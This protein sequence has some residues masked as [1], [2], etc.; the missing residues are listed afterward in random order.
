MTSN[1]TSTVRS[2]SVPYFSQWES[3]SLVAGIIAGT[4]SPADDPNWAS[5]GAEDIQEYVRWAGHLCGMACLKMIIAA[6]TGRVVPIL[7]LARQS[8]PYGAY[9]VHDEEIR[10]LIYAPFVSY[11][12]E[13]FGIESTV[14]SRVSAAD[15][16]EIMSRSE[17]FLASVHHSIRWANS[18]PANKGGHL[19]LI[20]ASS[21]EHFTF[22]NPSGHDERSQRDVTVSIPTFE[23]YFAG[24]G[25][26]ILPETS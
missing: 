17:F 10:G 4:A 11:V 26:A 25:I 21:D 14:V 3:P 7:A 22:H 13:S 12:R 15:I 1:R 23:R 8:M 24:R 5:S 2:N 9:V 18:I 6:R 19:V 16:P 20:T